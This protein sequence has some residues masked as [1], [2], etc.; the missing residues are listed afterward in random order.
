[1]SCA[2]QIAE[3]L[4]IRIKTISIDA[5]FENTRKIVDQNFDI[6][7]F[8]LVHEN[9]QARLRALLLMAYSNKASSMLLSTSNKSEI[10]A[11]FCT[12]YG[13]MCGGLAPIGDLTKGQVFE[14]ARLYN[15]SSEIIPQFVI[16]RPPSA[17]LRP[18]Q[19][20]EDNLPKY[21]LLDSSVGRIVENCRPPENETDSWLIQAI[22][23]SEFKRWQSPPILK[24]SKHAFGRGRRYPIAGYT[25]Y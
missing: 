11:G 17:E 24:V 3:N 4:K 25:E 8:C 2:R 22:G 7:N 20:D 21:N 10:A 13:D 19:K 14:L 9:L 16:D 12:L 18:N 23:K 15:A 6:K 5:L 1:M